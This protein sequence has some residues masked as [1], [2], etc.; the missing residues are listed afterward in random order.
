MR[1]GMAGVQVTPDAGRQKWGIALLKGAVTVTLLVWLGWQ[2]DVELLAH[3]LRQTAL[4]YLGLAYAAS[5]FLSV[6]GAW[7]W[8]LLLQPLQIRVPFRE[9]C[10]IMLL[11]NLFKYTLPGSLGEEVAKLYYVIKYAGQSGRQLLA[12]VVGQYMG[13]LALCILPLAVLPLRSVNGAL[14]QAIG[15]ACTVILAGLLLG[16]A[17]GLCL[18]CRPLLHA[19]KRLPRRV[20][21]LLSRLGDVLVAYRQHK[22]ALAQALAVALLMQGINCGIYYVLGR[23]VG[24]PNSLVDFLYVVPVVALTTLLP[25][26]FGGLGVHEWAFISLFADLGMSRETAASIALLRLAVTSG[27]VLLGGGVYL[28]RWKPMLWRNM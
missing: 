20:Q 2:L 23:G 9:L 19:A 18:S 28:M 8:Q 25:V 3:L 15:L 11:S 24:A 27:T 10:Y 6:L 22:K 16:L 14:A 26:S 5:I 17:V 21:A 4:P 7:R 13:S 1:D 12:A